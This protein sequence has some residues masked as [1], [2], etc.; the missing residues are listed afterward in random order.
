MAHLILYKDAN[1]QG[2]PKHV[3]DSVP[4]L[5]DFNDCTSSFVV[6]EGDWQFFIDANYQG[7]MGPTPHFSCGPG[8]KCQW[9]QDWGIENDAISSVKR[10]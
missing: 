9:V 4:F 7:L 6:L 8:S 2:N 1:F 3:Y 5:A 10:L